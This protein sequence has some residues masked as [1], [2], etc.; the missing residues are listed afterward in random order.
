MT[1]NE[2]KEYEDMVNRAIRYHC[3]N[4]VNFIADNCPVK[5]VTAILLTAIMLAD[6]CVQA[7]ME[8]ALTEKDKIRIPFIINTLLKSIEQSKNN[9]DKLAEFLKEV[10]PC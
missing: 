1:E 8:T 2:K 4:S 6:T 10:N 5:S 7:F 9:L 3:E